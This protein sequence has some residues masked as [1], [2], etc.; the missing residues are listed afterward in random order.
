MTFSAR[1]IGQLAAIAL[2]TSAVAACS[3]ADA[4]P[5]PPAPADVADPAG[6][7]LAEP[8]APDAA[9]RPA[10]QT[11][12]IV[13]TY[14]HDEGAFTQGLF[15]WNGALYE[16]TGRNGESTIRR[17]NIETGQVEQVR[18]IPPEY[19]GE[20]I[21]RWQDK[22]IALTWR[23]G[24]GFVLDLATFQPLSGFDYPG[25]GWGL[26]ANDTHLI[27]SDGSPV[28]RFLDPDTLKITDTLTVKL[29]GKPLQFL[30]ELEWVNGEIWANV[31][32][33]D[34][35]ARINPETGHVVAVIDFADLFP[36]IRR[37]APR[38]DV[39][40]GIAYDAETDR[41]FVTGK[42]WPAL[43]EIEVVGADAPASD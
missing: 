8:A 43:Y 7:T 19:F 30:N 17:T 10:I 42:H 14:P 41:I 37:N 28:L 24:R 27:Q 31:W 32:Q 6:P 40:N 34:Y 26:T 1:L 23:S 29:N 5:T 21:A 38:D 25:E 22:I 3:A 16:S 39:F 2:M 36:E 9:V 13:A 35:I 33:A 11:Y 18:D 15:F 20:G 4:P 12:K